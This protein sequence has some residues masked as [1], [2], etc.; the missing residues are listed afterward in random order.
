M[1]AGR[2]IILVAALVALASPLSAQD[3]STLKKDMVGQWELATTERSSRRPGTDP[4]A[5]TTASG[6]PSTTQSRVDTAPVRSESPRAASAD[7]LVIN[8]QNRVQGART[9]SP[10]TGSTI[11]PSA[12][13]AGSHSTRGSPVWTVCG[14]RV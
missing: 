1:F 10:I 7:S 8:V 11:S 5:S 2:P 13:D 6:P 12:A 14:S 4:R 9:N 3:A